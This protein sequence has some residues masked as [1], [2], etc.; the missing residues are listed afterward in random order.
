MALT[1]GHKIALAVAGITAVG[2]IIGGA[3]QAGG[4]GGGNDCS[5]GA[6]CGD[7][8]SGNSVS[9]DGKPDAEPS[10]KTDGTP[11]ATTETPGKTDGTPGAKP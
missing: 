5:Q 3:L 9:T 6:V 7:N 4:R 10:A 8:N 11:G 1:T 2:A